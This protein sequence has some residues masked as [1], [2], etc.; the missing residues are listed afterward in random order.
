MKMWDDTLSEDENI[1]RWCDRME[2]DFKNRMAKPRDK[3]ATW[4]ERRHEKGLEQ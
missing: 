3:D 2:R 1:Q 4:Q